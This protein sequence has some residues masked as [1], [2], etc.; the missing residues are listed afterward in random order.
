[1]FLLIMSLM[2]P[3]LQDDSGVVPDYSRM[4]KVELQPGTAYKFRVAGINICGRGAFSE[5]SAFKTCLP[6]FPGAPCAI[7]ISKVRC[8]L[9]GRQLSCSVTSRGRRTSCFHV[10][11]APAEPG[12]GPADL[13]ASRRH[14]GED[15][16]VL[17]LSG[18]PLQPGFLLLLLQFR[19]WCHPAGLHEG[20]L[21]PQPVLPGPVLQPRQRTHRLHNQT[22]H[23]LPHCSSQPEGLRSRHAGPV[24]A[25]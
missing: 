6:G 12:R 2:T 8:G 15:H 13:G 1:M 18:H 4:R 19:F 3:I 9:Y 5:V 21:W 7:K 10:T 16:R 11:S 17:R 14:V 22:R 20:L 23:H 25:R 24:A